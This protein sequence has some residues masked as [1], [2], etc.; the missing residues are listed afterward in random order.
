[1]T[2]A[3]M[4]AML[5]SARRLRVA[6]FVTLSVLLVGST[7]AL[8]WLVYNN[9]AKNLEQRLR[10]EGRSERALFESRLRASALGMQQL[11]AFIANLPAVQ[12]RFL[13]GTRAI[14]ADDAA[15]ADTARQSLLDALR[16]PLDQMRWEY[17]FAQLQ[18]LYGPQA[19]IFL[20]VQKPAR[21]GDPMSARAG[22][23]AAMQARS[24]QHG[25][26]LGP[27]FIGLHGLAPVFAR[28]NRTGAPQFI[29]MVEA[30]ITLESALA[31]M[32]PGDGLGYAVLLSLPEIKDRLAPDRLRQTLADRPHIG[33]GQILEAARGENIQALLRNPA[34][35]ALML[36]PGTRLVVHGGHHLLVSSFALRDYA[37]QRTGVVLTWRDANA[38]VAALRN[39]ARNNAVYAALMLLVT[40]SLLFFGL[41]RVSAR[42]ETIIAGQAEILQEQ[43]TR[44]P[45]TGLYN[46]RTLNE[47]LVRESAAA[48]RSGRPFALALVDLDHFKAINDTH[49]HAA[50]DAVL[51]CAADI[52]RGHIRAQD[53]ACRYGGEEFLLVLRDSDAGRAVALAERLRRALATASLGGLPAGRVT[54]SIG[55]AVFQPAPSETPE[56]TLRRADEALYRAKD[57]G[58]NRVVCATAPDAA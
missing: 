56:A 2:S 41:R 36:T 18:F 5:A 13:D 45:L 25:F 15:K 35:P 4:N 38:L 32:P 1:M 10:Q 42:F 49:G 58:R 52:M 9:D 33:S 3:A 21:Y 16:P 51:I 7:S 19:R 47:V 8:L 22:L 44:D 54:V 17:G 39:S 12:Q 20:R 6:L 55:V 57:E 43:A 46:R 14:T 40:E 11:A 31:L 48:R 30:G 34:L 23:I 37:G 29:G 50:G 26:E 24:A 28:E 27:D 53:I